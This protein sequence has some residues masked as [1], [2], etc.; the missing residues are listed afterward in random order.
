M[1]TLKKLSKG[2]E[3]LMD[4]NKYFISPNRYGSAMPWKLMQSP[5]GKTGQ[6]DVNTGNT[7]AIKSPKKYIPH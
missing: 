5:F 1:Q 7:I 2:Q 6:S 4:N 3:D